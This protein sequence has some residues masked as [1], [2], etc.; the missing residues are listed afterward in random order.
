MYTAITSWIKGA[1]VLDVHVSGFKDR[2]SARAFGEGV[3]SRSARALVHT[4][5][6]NTSACKLTL[7]LKDGERIELT[8]HDVTIV[9]LKTQA[10]PKPILQSSDYCVLDVSLKD[11]GS[12]EL[13]AAMLPR[14]SCTVLPTSGASSFRSQDRQVSNSDVTTP[15]NDACQVERSNRWHRGELASPCIGMNFDRRAR[16]GASK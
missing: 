12:L 10:L 6:P 4:K 15:N 11:L 14:L 7:L 9:G 3:G 1:I 8:D 16:H 5:I 2:E 13:D